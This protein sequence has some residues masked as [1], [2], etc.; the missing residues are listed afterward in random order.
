VL[1]MR[2]DSLAGTRLHFVS[3]EQKSRTFLVREAYEFQDTTEPHDP[4]LASF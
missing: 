4:H 2:K 3:K 1:Y